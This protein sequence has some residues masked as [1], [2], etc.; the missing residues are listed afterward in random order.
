MD[1]RRKRG[2]AILSLGIVGI[3][4][5]F[6]VWLWAETIFSSHALGN[7]FPGRQFMLIAYSWSPLAIASKG[8]F[9]I[10]TFGI[11]IIGRYKIKDWQYYLTLL[12]CAAGAAAALY[13]VFEVS[14]VD[15]ARRFWAYSPISALED[16][17]SFVSAAQIS[18]CAVATWLIVLLGIQ[19]GVK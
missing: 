6:V 18:L 2:A 7:N 16:Y 19:V 4:A 9:P 3:T 13:L 12:T 17:S 11:T 14:S 1:E 15:T 5:G 10:I 8:G